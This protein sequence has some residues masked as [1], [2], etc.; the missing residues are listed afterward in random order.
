MLAK[1]DDNFNLI[2]KTIY[3]TLHLAYTDY[4]NEL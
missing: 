3:F 4:I 2:L 1:G